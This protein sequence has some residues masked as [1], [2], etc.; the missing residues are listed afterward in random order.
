[1][2]VNVEK[3]PHRIMHEAGKFLMMWIDFSFFQS[4]EN[5]GKKMS[6][7]KRYYRALLVE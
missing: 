5:K 3:N 6:F 4:L 2:L 1:M 7:E